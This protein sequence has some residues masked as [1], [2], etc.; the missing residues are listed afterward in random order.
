MSKKH[1]PKRAPKRAPKPVTAQEIEAALR[2][3]AQARH[4]GDFTTTHL[5]V[6]HRVWRRVKKQLE[7]EASDA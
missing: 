5:I 4:M 6:A 1:A 2:P 3:F 7:A